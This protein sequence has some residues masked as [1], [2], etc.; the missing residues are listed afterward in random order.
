MTDFKTELE[1]AAYN[2]VDAWRGETPQHDHLHAHVAWMEGFQAGAKWALFES[3]I[4]KGL[5]GA[6]KKEFPCD[7]H[8][9]E[10]NTTMDFFRC[11]KCGIRPSIADAFAAFEKAKNDPA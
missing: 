10:P 9:M 2:R 8:D 5:V 7:E 6:L 4:V 11:D 1:R 3:E